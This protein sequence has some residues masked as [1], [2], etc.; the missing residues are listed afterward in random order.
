MGEGK[1]DR[2]DLLSHYCPNN[3]GVSGLLKRSLCYRFNAIT[4]G[5]YSPEKA[6]VGGSS[7]SLATTFSIAYNYSLPSFCSILFQFQIRLA[8]IC[9]NSEWTRRSPGLGTVMDSNS[10]SHSEVGHGSIHWGCQ[11]G[12]CFRW[13]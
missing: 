13:D 4:L 1:F 7:P 8:G 5:D 3:L 10:I 2:P 6:G 9:L 12:I 11:S